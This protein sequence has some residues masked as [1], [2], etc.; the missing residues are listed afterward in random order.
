MMKESSIVEIWGCDKIIL[1]ELK[2]DFCGLFL[3]KLFYDDIIVLNYN[4]YI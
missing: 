4:N 3:L 1:D 2:S